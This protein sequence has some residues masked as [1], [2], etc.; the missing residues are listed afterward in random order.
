MRKVLGVLS[1]HHSFNAAELSSQVRQVWEEMTWYCVDCN[2]QNGD[3]RSECSS[4]QKHWSLV[5]N[6]PKGRRRRSGSRKDKQ[7]KKEKDGGDVTEEQDP[8]LEVVPQKAPWVVS[9]PQSRLPK[10]EDS[11]PLPPPPRLNPPPQPPVESGQPS[12]PSG[13]VKVLEHLKGLRDAGCQ[14]PEPFLQQLQEMEQQAQDAVEKVQLSHSHLNKLKK[15]KGQMQTQQ[16]KIQEIDAQWDRF[17]KTASE[18]LQRHATMYQ[19]YRKD[20]VDIL[21]AKRAELHKVKETIT[22]ASKSLI[23]GQ[24]EP[25]IEVATGPQMAAAHQFEAM[26]E[27]MIAPTQPDEDDMDDD[28]VELLG[29]NGEPHQEGLAGGQ[30][31]RLSAFSHK[32]PTSPTK[33]APTIGK[34]TKASR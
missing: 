33:V 22:V 28:D 12:L 2:Q 31:K 5:W 7:K 16:K 18:N 3:R 1:T 17:V 6:P 19:S 20:M 9:T 32:S 30:K 29:A 26:A 25:E 15:L 10:V 21:E 27:E 4:C 14:L 23:A 34:Q 24:E 13:N 8:V 11:L